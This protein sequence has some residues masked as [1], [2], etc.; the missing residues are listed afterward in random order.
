[1][2]G[3]IWKPFWTQRRL[4]APWKRIGEWRYGFNDSKPRHH[5]EV[6]GQ[7]HSPAT[8]PP[9]KC[10][11]MGGRLVG[12]Q[13]VLTLCKQAKISFSCLE[14]NNDVSQGHSLNSTLSQ[15]R[16][17][18]GKEKYRA[19]SCPVCGPSLY[20]WNNYLILIVL[21]Q[22]MRNGNRIILD[23]CMMWLDVSEKPDV[24]TFNSSIKTG[25][26][27]RKNTVPL[28]CCT[29]CMHCPPFRCDLAQTTR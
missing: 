4:C 2:A 14:M 16:G 12:A 18:S 23:Y 27:P 21:Q 13:P 19:R 1:V 20:W 3:F 29:F 22:S 10:H 8:L 24:S 11:W 17:H 25:H 7:L 6:R 5:T 9:T 15:L 28:L 26:S